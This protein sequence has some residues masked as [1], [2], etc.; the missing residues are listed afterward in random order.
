MQNKLCRMT[1]TLQIAAILALTG[2][3]A[4]AQT[5]FKVTE[6]L[7]NQAANWSAGVPTTQEA[8]VGSASASPAKATLQDG[9][10]LTSGTLSI[11]QIAG[12][13]G[14]VHQTGGTL[15]LRT[16]YWRVGYRGVGTYRLENGQLL[17][18]APMIGTSGGTGT[19]YICGGEIQGAVKDSNWYLVG[20][21]AGSRGTVVQTSGVFNLRPSSP[22]VLALGG[23]GGQGFYELSGGSLTNVS[24]LYVYNGRLTL[25]NNVSLACSSSLH[26]G[27]AGGTGIV[28]QRN[29][30]CKTPTATKIGTGGTAVYTISGGSLTG[31]GLEVG[32]GS[33]AVGTLNIVDDATV[34][35]GY[36]WVG[37]AANATGFVYQASGTMNR[38][39]DNTQIGAGTGAYGAY[40]LS[41]GMLTN[42]ASV[43]VGNGL[44]SL[45]ETGKIIL[46][47]K[48][49]GIGATTGTGT[50]Q[51]I[52]PHTTF[53]GIYDFTHNKAGSVLDM[54]LMSDGI[55][56]LTVGGNGNLGGTLSLGIQGG[57]AC[58]QTNAF[59]FLSVRWPNGDFATKKTGVF[60][61]S[62]TSGK[63]TAT[64]A[65]ASRPAEQAAPLASGQ[66][67]AFSPVNQG[68]LAID[69]AGV[70]R[71]YD[72][73]LAV[74]APDGTPTSELDALVDY[75]GQS[76]LAV[77]KRQSA[78]NAPNIRISSELGDAEAIRYLA[79]DFA[80]FNPALG[81]GSV[82]IV[83]P[84]GTVIV[85]R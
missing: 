30:S 38:G 1:R 53:S 81:V 52:G 3:C 15:N 18:A 59:L 9:D 33:G 56:T 75:L 6:G 51:I 48:N 83:N 8:R 82:G 32:C 64:L 67:L 21:G 58:F 28:D 62:A 16:N 36:L 22:F 23:N 73:D 71:A 14:E 70:E 42:S 66:S 17:N 84:Y 29:A 7:W 61:T 12:A 11:G 78:W 60:S 46:A 13:M 45:S 80:S 68:W 35:G 43:S 39:N 41:G 20:D 24:T 54:R 31:G 63:Y 2:L 5:E 65:A 76:G 19:V 25:S 27:R 85:I 79:W 4:N 10:L 44:L 57:V 74:Y 37:G 77:A 34:K 55:S 26:L 72:I 50:L 69:V 40:Y 49:V 47:N